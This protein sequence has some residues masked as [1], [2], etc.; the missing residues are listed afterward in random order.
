[1][2]EAEKILLY[3]AVC[4]DDVFPTSAGTNVTPA[5]FED[6]LIHLAANYSLLSLNDLVQVNGKPG[7]KSVAVTFDDGYADNYIVAYPI[8]KKYAV[9]VTFFLT[10]SRIGRDW[11]FPDGPYPGI[12]WD[13]IRTLNDDPLIDFGS[14]GYR[15]LDLTRLS[16]AEARHE[17]EESKIILESKLSSPV[18]YFSYPHGSYNDELIEMIRNAGYRSAFSVISAN[19]DNYS[20]RRILISSKDNMFRFKLKLSPLYW[21]LRKIM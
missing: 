8:I 17:I 18:K 1:M 6:Q 19:R 12:S 13:D 16:P 10:I 11:D 7:K 2:I 9:P 3:H 21:P 14:H 5:A 4:K 20:L 15:H